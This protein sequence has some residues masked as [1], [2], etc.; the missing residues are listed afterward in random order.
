MDK[1]KVIGIQH[2]EGIAKK[3]QRPYKADILHVE[4]LVTPR[5]TGFVGHEVGEVWCDCASGVCPIV[6]KVGDI[7]DVY[8]N[9]SGFVIGVTICK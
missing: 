4:Y 8:Y 3:T 1:A 7:V 9:R 2:R 6:P 5:G